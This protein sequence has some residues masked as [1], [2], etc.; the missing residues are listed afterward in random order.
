MSREIKV[1]LAED[2]VNLGFVIRDNLEQN[3]LMVDLCKDGEEALSH[4]QTKDY[5]ICILDVMMPKMDGFDVATNIRKKDQEIPIL[6]LTAKTMKEDRLR[7]FLVGGDDYITK[8]FSIE[9]LICRINVF[10]KRSKA[11]VIEAVP[12]MHFGACTFDHKNL[13]IIVGKDS[14]RVTQMEADIL[15]LL[16]EKKKEMW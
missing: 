3:G 5:H 7:G 14:T 12:I 4:F 9:E 13:E 8:P 6:F 15:L 2:D 10:L 1:L 11:V 16:L